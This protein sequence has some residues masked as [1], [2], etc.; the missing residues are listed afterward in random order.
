MDEDNPGYRFQDPFDKVMLTKGIDNQILTSFRTLT[1]AN[2]VVSDTLK[3]VHTKFQPT[4]VSGGQAKKIKKT[5]G[6]Q[7]YTINEEVLFSNPEGAAD[8]YMEAEED[9]EEQFTRQESNNIQQ[10][11]PS[12]ESLDTMGGSLLQAIEQ[13]EESKQA[14][15]NVVFH[16]QRPGPA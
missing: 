1:K 14:P 12:A 13:P 11:H 6:K 3:I 5:F 9:D 15:K 16:Q 8:Q 4:P 2:N 10:H 7:L